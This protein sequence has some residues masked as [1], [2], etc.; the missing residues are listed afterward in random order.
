MRCP[1]ETPEGMERLL[2]YGAG[3]SPPAD[4]AALKQHLEICPACRDVVSGHQAVRASLDQW[5]A[6][7][8]SAD[9]NR[10]LYHRIGTEVSWFV[11]LLRPIRPLFVW[12]AIPVG[13]AA[14]LLVVIGIALK[15]TGPVTPAT[16]NAPIE[17]AHPEQVIHALDV[18][19]MLDTLDATGQ[20]DAPKS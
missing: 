16:P 12:R 1:I 7:P 19:E 5:E 10:R 8:V 3:Q 2:D 11:R 14:C 6:P 15:Q 13:A 17:I 9:F 18:M 4:A 20:A